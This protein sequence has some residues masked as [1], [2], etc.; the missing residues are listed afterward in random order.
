MEQPNLFATEKERSHST[1]GYEDE[2]IQV[3]EG[4]TAIR[5]RPG[6]YIGTTGA[7]GLHHLV[8]EIIDNAVDEHLANYCNEIEVIIHKDDS[9]TV[10]DDGRGIPTGMHK[11]GVPTP[12]VVF[13]ILQDRKST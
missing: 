12:Q 7:A 5:K 4:L 13:T 1:A 3:L 2:H 8:W 6:M 11:T 9:I 10:I